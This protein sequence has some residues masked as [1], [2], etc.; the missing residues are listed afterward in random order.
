M[1]AQMVSGVRLRKGAKK[2]ALYLR[3]PD[4]TVR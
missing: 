3:P 4:K 1:R 2:Q